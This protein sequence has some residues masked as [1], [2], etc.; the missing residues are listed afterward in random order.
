[1]RT[2]LSRCRHSRRLSMVPPHAGCL[3]P[4]GVCSTLPFP[5]ECACGPAQHSSWFTMAHCLTPCRVP[6]SAPCT[7]SALSVALTLSAIQPQPLPPQLPA[8]PRH[9]RRQVRLARRWRAKGV[10]WRRGRHLCRGPLRSQPQRWHPDR[11]GRPQ[12]RALRGPKQQQPPAKQGLG[13]CQQ[14]A[15]GGPSPMPSQACL[16]RLHLKHELCPGVPSD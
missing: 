8:G 5:F 13:T 15:L 12:R 16:P 11:R 6:C 9:A 14:L 2:S 3:T 4:S 1:M 10:Q 7:P